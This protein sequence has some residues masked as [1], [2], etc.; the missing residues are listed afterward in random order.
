MATNDK[1]DRQL[2]L[3]GAK[4]QRALGDTNVFLVGASAAGTETLKVRTITGYVTPW[5]KSK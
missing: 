3:W 1:Y 4:G 2:R 5:F